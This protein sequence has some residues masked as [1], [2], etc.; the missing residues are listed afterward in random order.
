MTLKGF[1]ILLVFLGRGGV[2]HG[3]GK[4]LYLA[5]PCGLVV[6][7]VVNV[8]VF[9]E[10]GANFLG[11]HALWVF[12][13][14][15]E[16]LVIEE[17][18]IVLH[19]APNGDILSR[20]RNASTDGNYGLRIFRVGS[21]NHIEI[22]VVFLCPV[23]E[24]APNLL[25]GEHGNNVFGNVAELVK[26][27]EGAGN[28][29]LVGGKLEILVRLLGVRKPPFLKVGV[30]EGEQVLYYGGNGEALC[31]VE[32]QSKLRVLALGE[33]ALAAAVHLHKLCGVNILRHFPA[34]GRE[35]LNVHRPCGKPFLAAN[36]MGGTHKVVVHHMGEVIGGY[37]VGLEQ[38]NVLI[39]FRH[40]YF[41]LYKV[42]KV[43]IFF[44]VAFAAKTKHPAFIFCQSGLN[45]LKGAVAPNGPFAV[46]AGV[47]AFGF[48]RLAHGGKL[49]L[50]AEA[51]VGLALLNKLFGEH[52]V[53]VRSLALTVGTVVAEFSV[54]KR[55]LVKIKSEFF[56][57]GDYG[58][59]AAFHLALFVGVLYAEHKN[60]AALVGEAF[61]GDGTEQVAK[62][63]KTGWAWR[64]TG[65][66]CAFGKVSRR[67]S[68]FHIFRCGGH[69]RKKKIGKFFTVHNMFFLLKRDSLLTVYI[70]I[71]SYLYNFDN[72]FLSKQINGLPIRFLTHK[73][74]GKPKIEAILHQSKQK[75]AALSLNLQKIYRNGEEPTGH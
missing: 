21:Q 41:A 46:I 4:L 15:S 34:K 68:L 60:A 55:A 27:E 73:N 12:A 20:L 19:F 43:N 48:L 67:I 38:N 71:L 51:G 18:H 57:H 9:F 37:A 10:H 61:I 69:I 13:A 62:V 42:V 14:G 56:E 65:D 17:R 70:N 36:H 49:I 58:L 75:G 30:E 64:H 28:T 74:Y 63:H 31:K 24:V 2:A 72:I 54:G 22:S 3:D 7:F 5:E 33:L 6:R 11:A 8:L 52:M 45:I 32:V 39:V 50:G 53:N 25:G 47:Y 44:R 59:N 35:K 23:G 40:I 26:V 1:G 16:K 66:L 29:H